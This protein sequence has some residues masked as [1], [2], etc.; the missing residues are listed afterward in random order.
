MQSHAAEY[1]SIA[2]RV[3]VLFT[4]LH[5]GGPLAGEVRTKL[6]GGRVFFTRLRSGRGPPEVRTSNL[7]RRRGEMGFCHHPLL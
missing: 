4:R 2:T 5:G 1:A 7:G 3:R 6:Y